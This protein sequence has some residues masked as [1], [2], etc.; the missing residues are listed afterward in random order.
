MT[1]NFH[2]ALTCLVPNHER[3]SPLF[4]IF[5]PSIKE[6]RLNLSFWFL[7]IVF[8]YLVYITG[9]AEEYQLPYFDLVTPDPSFEEMKRVVAI[10]RR[11]PGFPNR[12]SQSKVNI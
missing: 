7:Q 12:W 6:G 3:Y 11:R 8:N 10:D 9:H 4:D 2:T 1:T 5:V